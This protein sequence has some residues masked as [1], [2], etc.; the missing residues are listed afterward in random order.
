L[1]IRATSGNAIIEEK[2]FGVKNPKASKFNIILMITSA[3]VITNIG[4][5]FVFDIL[6][7]LL[8]VTVSVS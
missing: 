8:V 7:C 3:F 5:L 4:C 6:L 2:D 1:I